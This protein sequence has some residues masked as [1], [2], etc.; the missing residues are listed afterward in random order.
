MPRLLVQPGFWRVS[1]VLES[2]APENCCDSGLNRQAAAGSPTSSQNH[3]R[4]IVA[5]GPCVEGGGVESPSTD[6]TS[7]PVWY[8]DLQIPGLLRRSNGRSHPSP[9][10]VPELS[11]EIPSDS[12]C[13]DA[14]SEVQREVVPPAKLGQP[15]ERDGLHLELAILRRQISALKQERDEL[16]G[17]TT[18]L[19]VEVADLQTRREELISLSADIQA[20][21][22]RKSSLEISLAGLLRPAE[23]IRQ[24]ARS[25][26]THFHD[27]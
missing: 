8:F 20:L 11:I 27:S 5:A 4:V 7:G 2:A 18:R 14:P 24:F 19:S 21:D 3:P 9:A 23:A 22:W 10:R 6:L 13:Q 26:R 12:R 1:D 16:L 15:V 25:R 17:V